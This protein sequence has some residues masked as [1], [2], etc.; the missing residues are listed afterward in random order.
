[1]KVEG[2][3]TLFVDIDGTLLHHYGIANEQ[4]KF[5][6]KLLPGVKEKLIE[7][8][9]SGYLLILTTGRRESE[10]SET[11]LQLQ[12]AG[13]QYDKLI[14]G[15]QRGDR[16]IINDIKPNSGNHHTAVAI[17]VERNKGIENV[18]L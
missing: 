12:E 16:V 5:T 3:K 18:E 2:L 17:N 11:I 6:T 14:M 8:N 7:W 13:I 10:R 4:T 9:M 1:M 15:I